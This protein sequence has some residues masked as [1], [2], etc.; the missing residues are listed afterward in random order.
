MARSLTKAQIKKEIIASGKNPVYFIDNYGK[1]AHP[2]K[3]TIPFSMYAFQKDVV[4]DYQDNR[5]NIILKARQLG[6]STVTAV[7]IA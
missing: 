6:L 7:Y 5:F 2:M 4:G 1:I 3:G